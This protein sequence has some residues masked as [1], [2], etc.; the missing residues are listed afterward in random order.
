MDTVCPI[1]GKKVVIA[2]VGKVDNETIYVE[3]I[4]ETEG[5]SFNPI[6]NFTIEEIGHPPNAYEYIYYGKNEPPSTINRDMALLILENNYKD[7]YVVLYELETKA[8][9]NGVASIK[10]R[11]G[12]IE[13]IAYKTRLVHELSLIHI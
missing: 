3:F 11:F 7:P 1:C 9:T 6:H 8:N 4:C 10:T 2:S 13:V 5:C 12:R